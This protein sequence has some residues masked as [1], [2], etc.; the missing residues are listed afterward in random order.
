MEKKVHFG[1]SRVISLLKFSA[2]QN[3]VFQNTGGINLEAEYGILA[4]IF[5]LFCLNNE[6]TLKWHSFLIS[7]LQTRLQTHYV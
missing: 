5:T 6:K 4:P 2:E 3:L 1:I 7:W